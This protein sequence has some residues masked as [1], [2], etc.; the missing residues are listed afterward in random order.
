M[1]IQSKAGPILQSSSLP[2]YSVRDCSDGIHTPHQ[3]DTAIE[4]TVTR[5]VSLKPSVPSQNSFLPNA[6]ASSGSEKGMPTQQRLESS[7][8]DSNPNIVTVD[9]EENDL[10]NP[11]N[12]SSTR[13]WL[14]IFAISWMG[15]VA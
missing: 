10:A 2:V 7:P 5:P 4:K 15:F 14:M 11:V 12:W 3:L 8:D 6:M 9:Y 13:K 1:L